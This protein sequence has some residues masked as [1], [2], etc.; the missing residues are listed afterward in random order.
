MNK[1]VVIISV[2]DTKAMIIFDYS[3]MYKYKR[4]EG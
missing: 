3:F 4:K 2:L 1:Y